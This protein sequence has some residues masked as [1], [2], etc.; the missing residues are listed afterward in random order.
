MDG[1]PVIALLPAAVRVVDAEAPPGAVELDGTAR[2]LVA[3]VRIGGRPAGIGV[4]SIE[5]DVGGREA[6]LVRAVADV[7]SRDGSPTDRPR[8]AVA[9]VPSQVSVV[10]TTCRDPARARRCVRSVLEGDLAPHEVI[11]VEN[12]PGDGLTAAM[13]RGEFGDDP[14]SCVEEDRPGL[15]R[16]RNAGLRAATGDLV[17]F[18]DDDVVADRRW[19]ASASA[20][21]GFAPDASAVTGLILPLALDDPTQLLFEQFAGFGKGLEVRVH[22]LADRD[23][24]L[25]EWAPGRFG[26]GANVVVRA[27]VLRRVGGFDARLGTGTRAAGGED[28]DLFI[29][30]LHD[31]GALVYE[32]AAIVQHDHPHDPQRLRH[33]AFAY[34]AG[35]T[36][37]LTKHAVHGPARASL[38]RAVPAGVRYALDPASPKNAGRPVSFPRALVALERAGMACGP[39]AY[40]RSSATRG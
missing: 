26:S 23:H 25:G 36:A 8:S 24:P 5:P 27:D 17:A 6:A 30:L 7:T 15:S 1:I 20:A 21:F 14:V 28:L 39:L 2:T 37:A 31:G 35:L 40:A 3:L 29:R 32:P 10:I 33:Q 16:A 9:P 38:A 13:V 4:A 34:G 22:R 19:L 18:T 11:V 12:R